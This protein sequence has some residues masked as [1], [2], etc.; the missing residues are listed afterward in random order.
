MSTTAEKI[1]D[2]RKRR[3]LTQSALAEK[4]NLHVNTILGLEAGSHDPA[5]STIEAVA[6]AM[7]MPA[8]DLLGDEPSGA[9]RRP[10]A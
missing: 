4:A 7:G 2:A 10:A 8:F 3:K 1:R 6:T 5:L 9:K